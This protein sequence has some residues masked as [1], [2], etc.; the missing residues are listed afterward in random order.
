MLNA[1]AHAHAA[2]SHPARLSLTRD[3]SRSTVSKLCAN[4]DRSSIKGRDLVIKGQAFA[5]H[6]L[7]RPG[8]RSPW[9]GCSLRLP[10]SSGHHATIR[11]KKMTMAHLKIPGQ[12]LNQYVSFFLF[13]QG[14]SLREVCTTVIGL[15]CEINN[16]HCARQLGRLMGISG[17]TKFS[18]CLS[19][20]L[21]H[22]LARSSRSTLV[23]T[24]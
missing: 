13:Q 15:T 21:S 19:S 6:A 1:L 4:L 17:L 10:A 3:C 22:A 5:L 16:Q 12:T 14:Y 11:S 7:T 9:C 20:L 23:S 24:T 18:K 2:C 8:P